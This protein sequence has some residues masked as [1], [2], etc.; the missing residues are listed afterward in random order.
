MER[1]SI[2]TAERTIDNAFRVSSVDFFYLKFLVCVE[3]RLYRFY[4]R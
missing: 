1:I 2:I 4:Q 3:R